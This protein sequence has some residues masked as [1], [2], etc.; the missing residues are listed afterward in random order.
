MKMTTPCWTEKQGRHVSDS[1]WKVWTG[2]ASL[3]IM[4]SVLPGV[5]CY[6]PRHGA[7]SGLIHHLH[8]PLKCCPRWANLS[9]PGGG[10]KPW[11][12]WG[13]RQSMSFLP[14]CRCQQPPW[15]SAWAAGEL[16]HCHLSAV[17]SHYWKPLSAERLPNAAVLI[18]DRYS[19]FLSAPVFSIVCLHG[20]LRA[21]L[22]WLQSK[23]RCLCKPVCAAQGWL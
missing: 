3:D 4:A 20:T 17:A 7:S 18:L 2:R 12:L 5:P 16:F 22:D 8:Q 15:N 10:R 9:L 23:A 1:A 11:D 21:F 19:S 13:E 6:T 14:S